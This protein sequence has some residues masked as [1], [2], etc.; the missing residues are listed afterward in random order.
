M[1]IFI[2]LSDWL[3]ESVSIVTHESQLRLIELIFVV[4]KKN[5]KSLYHFE[6]ISN[7]QELTSVFFEF[8]SSLKP[9]CESLTITDSTV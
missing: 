8:R 9:E 4:C 6:K 5:V 1:Y 7:G 2:I 3:Y